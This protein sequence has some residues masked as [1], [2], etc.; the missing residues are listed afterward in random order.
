MYAL[1]QFHVRIYKILYM[2]NDFV[3]YVGTRIW[4]IL[5]LLGQYHSMKI[6]K[7]K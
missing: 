4:Q 3:S 1:P 6:L 2:H 7:T 5:H